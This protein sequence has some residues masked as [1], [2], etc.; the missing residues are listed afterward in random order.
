MTSAEESAPV[1][2]L[3]FVQQRKDI[4]REQFDEYW[5][6]DHA[7]TLCQFPGMK[8]HLL[9][10]EQVGACTASMR[11]LYRSNLCKTWPL[12]TD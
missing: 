9:R 12:M 2:L 1:T 11:Y 3:I 6:K 7:Q 10:Y 5:R 4:T 8:K